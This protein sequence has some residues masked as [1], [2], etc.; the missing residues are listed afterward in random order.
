M[1]KTQ[2]KH[3]PCHMSHVLCDCGVT[4]RQDMASDMSMLKGSEDKN[5]EF[6]DQCTHR[7]GR[8]SENENL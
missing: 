7:Q 6:L 3:V 2:C 5:C 1:K 4:G 8:Y